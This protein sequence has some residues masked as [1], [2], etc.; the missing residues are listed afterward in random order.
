MKILKRLLAWL[1]TSV[2]A[3]HAAAL[4]KAREKNRELRQALK[5]AEETRDQHAYRS[6]STAR[7][8]LELEKTIESLHD[9][10]QEI[11]REKLD[12][13]VKAE[14]LENAKILN[15]Q[16]ITLLQE[17]VTAEIER[18]RIE[19]LTAQAESQYIRQQGVTYAP[20]Q[21]QRHRGAD[22]STA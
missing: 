18:R 19:R 5:L 22:Q 2:A 12:L 11:E 16:A 21:S 7:A 9:R 13:E 3:E 10:I 4:A 20:D 17:T 1:L 15:E 6:E 14:R 8:S